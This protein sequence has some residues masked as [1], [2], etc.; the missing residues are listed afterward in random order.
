MKYIVSFII[1]FYASLG[2]S[3]L[4]EDNNSLKVL[5]VGNSITYFNDMPQSFQKIAHSLGDNV[6]LQVYAPGGT[7]FVHHIES[8]ELFDLF[9]ST[10]WDYVVLQPGS[11]ESISHSYPIEVTSDRAQILLDSIYKYSPCAKVFYYEISYGVWGNTEEN[12]NTY[13]ET[14][15]LIR[16]NVEYL[17]QH[18]SVPFVPAGEAIRYAWNLD[19]SE[20]LWGSTGDIHPNAKGSYIIA[21]AM[22]ASIFRKESSYSDFYA[23]LTEEDAKR[24]QRIAD[25][26]VLNHQEDWYFD[27]Y[28]PIIDWH[29][30]IQQDSLSFYHQSVRVDSVEWNFGDNVLSQ[31]D[32]GLHIYSQSGQ[33]QLQFTAY[34]HACPISEQK[35]IEIIKPN[36]SVPY[37]ALNEV[38]VF[39]NPT[40]GNVSVEYSFDDGLIEVYDALGKKCLVTKNKTFNLSSFPKG[41]YW[42]KIVNLTES[43]WSVYKLIKE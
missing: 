41:I 31:Q 8:D 25:S 10:Q 2:F 7:G 11:S 33:Y 38:R 40:I 14:M 4:K 30:E 20:M 43:S 34:Q 32:S 42:V 36:V 19:T 13:N 28:R 26:I 9:R 24:F 22:Y 12:L 35:D 21:C 27:A 17:S 29:Y 16:H 3:Q 37:I 1:V 15:D 39:P 18:T 23:T 5:F 6:D